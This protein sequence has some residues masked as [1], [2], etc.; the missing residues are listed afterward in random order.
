MSRRSSSRCESWSFYG[1]TALWRFGA[2]S[3]TDR[4]RRGPGPHFP[5]GMGE[6]VTAVDPSPVVARGHP[7]PALHRGRASNSAISVGGS[8]TVRGPVLESTSWSSP[9]SRSTVRP[10]HGQGLAAAATGQHQQTD[11]RHGRQ[12]DGAAVGH[13]VQHLP[14]PGEPGIGREPLAEPRGVFLDRPA[15]IEALRYRACMPLR[16]RYTRRQSNGPVIGIRE[17]VS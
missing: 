10:A 11:R 17:T 14:A 8:W 4:V 7:G 15:G 12:R 3:L 9:A 6:T 1:R 2:N 13:L 5:P 16:A